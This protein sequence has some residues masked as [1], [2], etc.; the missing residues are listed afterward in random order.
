MTKEPQ[1]P[2]QPVIIDN[3]GIARFKANAIVQFLLD[4]GPNNMNRLSILPFSEDDW[5]QFAQLIGYSV[6]GFGG[7]SYASAEQV[8]AAD[9]IV[10][11]LIAKGK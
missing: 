8:E 5:N 6:S 9:K 7:L 11:E 10:E 1:H 4:N 3:K 2:M